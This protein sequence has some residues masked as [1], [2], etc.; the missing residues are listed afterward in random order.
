MAKSLAISNPTR[1]RS[2]IAAIRIT[3]ISAVDSTLVLKQFRSDC[4]CDFAGALRFQ[5]LNSNAVS[6]RSDWNFSI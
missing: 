3:A 2:E 6:N 4:A 1:Q 5:S